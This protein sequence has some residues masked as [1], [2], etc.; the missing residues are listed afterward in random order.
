LNA[1]AHRSENKLNVF[2]NFEVKVDEVLKGSNLTAGSVIN[3]QRIGG[4]VNYPNGK[5]VLFRLVGNGMP[6]VGSRY[7]LFLTALDED[8]RILTAYELA[9]GGVMPLDNSRQFETYQGKSEADFLKVLR[10]TVSQALP[11]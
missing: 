11:Q 6:A 5:K 2:S 3:V 10:E 9:P 1:E 8:Y 7:V 4:F